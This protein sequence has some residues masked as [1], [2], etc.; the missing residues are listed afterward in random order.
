M[1]KTLAK[2][3]AKTISN[4]QLQEMF[5]TAKERIKDWTVVSS[6][7]K[8]MTKGTGWNILA[9]NFNVDDTYHI[10][11]K[12]NMIREFGE[13]L[14]EELKPSKIQKSDGLKPPI[15]QVHIF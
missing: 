6:V 4:E 10:L 8:G 15:H 13:F 1:N 5:N 9:K 3:I 12:T 11:A 14:S 2:K 7:N